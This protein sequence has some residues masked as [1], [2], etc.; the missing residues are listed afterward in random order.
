MI[1]RGSGRSDERR[2]AWRGATIAWA[3]AAAPQDRRLTARTLLAR[4]LP[5]GTEFVSV[6]PECGGSHG[7]VLARVPGASAASPA[8][9]VSIAYAGELVAVGAA[10]A[11][12]GAF[13]I[14]AE[15]DTPSRHRAVQEALGS[16]DLRDWT[17]YEAVAK[18]RRTGILHTS[19]APVRAANGAEW[20]ASAKSGHP[21]LRGID[22][23]LA[24]PGLPEQAI[25]SVALSTGAAHFPASAVSGA[26]AGETPRASASTAARAAGR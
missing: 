21:A 13:G 10:P 19:P 23:R 11:G 9:L 1:A 7:P 25:V 17:R 2:L 22:L 15:L 26:E 16:A 14:D 20:I 6:C 3:L 8:P 5:A 18:A 24:H 4:L 12:A